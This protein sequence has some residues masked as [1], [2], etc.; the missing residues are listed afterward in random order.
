[1]FL[2]PPQGSESVDFHLPIWCLTTGSF[3]KT[4]RWFRGEVRQGSHLKQKDHTSHV[5]KVLRWST[6][7]QRHQRASWNP[8]GLSPVAGYPP[9][10]LMAHVLPTLWHL[11]GSKS[12]PELKGPGG[13]NELCG[14]HVP[15]RS[16]RSSSKSTSGPHHLKGLRAKMYYEGLKI[17]HGCV[18]QNQVYLGLS[19]EL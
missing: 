17:G 15:I 4:P 13:R 2:V 6:Q 14:R 9:W 3:P 11:L 18:L 19:R 5:P 16:V 8:F 1:M 12:G 7:I 10:V